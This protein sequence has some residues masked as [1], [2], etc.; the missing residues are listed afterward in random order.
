LRCAVSKRM[1][2][3]SVSLVAVLR[4]ACNPSRCALLQDEVRL[5]RY[6]PK[7]DKL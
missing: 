7:R 4:D 3:G 6:E 1:A 5:M 2:A